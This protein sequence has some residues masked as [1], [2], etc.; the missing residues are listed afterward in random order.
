LH[1]AT[2]LQE[3]Q[4]PLPWLMQGA[5]F[6]ARP[7]T[8]RKLTEEDRDRKRFDYFVLAREPEIDTATGL[9][10]PSIDGSL[11]TRARP[12]TSGE[13]PAVAIDFNPKG[14]ALLGEL[15]R[16][17]VPTGAAAADTQLK[18]HLAIILDG[19]VMSAPTINSEIRQAAHISGRFTTTEVNQLA[20]ML[21]A[22]ALPCRLRPL[23][24]SEKAVPP[25]KAP[26]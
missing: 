26:Q 24:T 7:C 12:T 5:L 6:Y 13:M 25:Q 19:L 14:A 1:E 20:A 23:P 15:T 3:M 22:G 18:R 16:K 9:P 10:T 17:N 8:N 21:K 4:W 2:K 11:L